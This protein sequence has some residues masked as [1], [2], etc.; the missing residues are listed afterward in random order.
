MR[1]GDYGH[2]NFFKWPAA[3]GHRLGFQR[4]RNSAVRSAIPENPTQ[5]PNTKWIE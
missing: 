5:E 2:L 1:F 3:A 4:T